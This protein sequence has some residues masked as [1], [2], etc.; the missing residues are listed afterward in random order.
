[1]K[2]FTKM[3][4]SSV[5]DGTVVHRSSNASSLNSNMDTEKFP[6]SVFRV[7]VLKTQRGSNRV[8]IKQTHQ[9][10]RFE[11]FTWRPLGSCFL[12][13]AVGPCS[14]R[15][16]D[17]QTLCWCSFWWWRQ[18]RCC[19]WCLW[20]WCVCHQTPAG[21]KRQR[22]EQYVRFILSFHHLHYKIL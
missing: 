2:T 9:I 5:S 8:M 4:S 19:G 20:T 7:I 18:S 10:F 17:T 3:S 16:N 1:M 11:T 21:N 12:R 22:D 13:W 15:G 14:W 6:S